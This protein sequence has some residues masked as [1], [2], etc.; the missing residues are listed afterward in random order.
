MKNIIK[1][2]IFIL[3]IPIIMSLESCHDLKNKA[4]LIIYNAQ[5]YSPDSLATGVNCIA[6]KNGKILAFGTDGKIRS[7]YWAPEN[8]DAAGGY[9]YPGFTDAHAHFTGFALGLRYADLTQAS[10][11]DDVLQI[12]VDYRKLHPDGWIVGQGWDQNNWPGK[13]FPE[14]KC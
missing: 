7:R 4:D 14:T 11:F 5:I 8:I 3:L 2:L 13:R 1:P 6:V 9:I 12:L 10:S